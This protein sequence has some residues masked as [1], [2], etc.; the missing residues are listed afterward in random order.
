MDSR[1]FEAKASVHRPIWTRALRVRQLLGA[2][3]PPSNDPATPLRTLTGTAQDQKFVPHVPG[4][5]S[6]HPQQ[7]S[8]PAQL[9]PQTQ[10]DHISSRKEKLPLELQQQK[11]EDGH[12]GVQGASAQPGLV[13][14]DP[15]VNLHAEFSPSHIRTSLDD[16]ARPRDNSSR[17]APP[18]VQEQE[19]TRSSL[20][21]SIGTGTTRC[22]KGHEDHFRPTS[23]LS[24]G[25]TRPQPLPTA[26]DLEIKTSQST[27]ENADLHVLRHALF[28]DSIP[29]WDGNSYP[30]IPA[31]S[32]ARDTALNPS[33]AQYSPQEWTS[34]LGSKNPYLN[35]INALR[36]QE[37]PNMQR[38]ALA[39]SSTESR[40]RLNGKTMASVRADI[41]DPLPLADI[42][43]IE[44]QEAVY[45]S[46]TTI[47]PS[48]LTI[49]S[50]T[51][52]KNLDNTS[53]NGPS[54]PAPMT[55]AVEIPLSRPTV[56]RLSRTYFMDRSAILPD[57]VF[58]SWNDIVRRRLDIDL[59]RIIGG[60]STGTDYILSTT[61]LYMAGVKHGEVIHAEPTIV[62]TCGTKECKKRV[63][64]HFQSVRPHYLD[65]FGQPVKVRY[66]RPP[67]YWATRASEKSFAA[68]V[69]P[70]LPDLREVWVE[71][72][73]APTRC[74]C[75][76]R[77]DI[78]RNGLRRQYYATYGGAVR[79]AGRAY[80]MTTAHTFRT[81]LGDGPQAT[82]AEP[83]DA[84]STN[85]SDIDIVLPDP[86][87]SH[88]SSSDA[89]LPFFPLWYPQL[90]GPAFYSFAGARVKH[91]RKAGYTVSET[92]WALFSFT[93]YLLPNLNG[94]LELLSII[95][96]QEL[97]AGDVSI[98]CDGSMKGYMTQSN[99]SLHTGEFSMEVKEIILHSPIVSAASGSWI[100]RADRICGYIVAIDGKA[101]SCFMMPMQRAFRD[102]ESALGKQLTLGFV[103]P[104]EL[105]TPSAQGET[106]SV[107]AEDQISSIP[108]VGPK[109]AKTG[110]QIRP[111][112]DMNE[113]AEIRRG[114]SLA[115]KG[116]AETQNARDITDVAN[117]QG[118]PTLDEGE[119]REVSSAGCYMFL[120]RLVCL[121][122][123]K[124][125]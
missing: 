101:L 105:Y 41:E 65:H 124:E 106:R 62:I 16:A 103:A 31:S 93:D 23:E 52:C 30:H 69:K 104:E 22:E 47:R 1:T 35:K 17:D 78:E 56:E 119:E 33:G 9:L 117:R 89:Y 59:Q 21:D 26:G 94:S 98:L 32:P 24:D 12:G 64:K 42:A 66:Q 76:L 43:N 49:R 86:S 2:L 99:A 10:S 20:T 82:L 80:A 120:R 11:E 60:V 29:T 34:S 15:S 72:K 91:S 114:I 92:D 28:E 116:K 55:G 87:T 37:I 90:S 18:A 58:R 123:H 81:C 79:L 4:T 111:P 46:S 6:E 71:H 19:Q 54:V 51:A 96:E 39:S 36:V 73:N 85:S 108:E 107:D 48:S 68:A 63:R 115:A 118:N 75:N 27:V 14:E 95:P 97:T 7:T 44:P 88:D 8:T 84:G 67:S 109:P 74:G 57:S 40:Q 102:I 122:R 5:P 61:Q 112:E 53:E 100:V 38:E 121:G 3:K 125:G 13:H 25:P 50:S 83:D 45:P 113:N 110:D 70:G 77:F